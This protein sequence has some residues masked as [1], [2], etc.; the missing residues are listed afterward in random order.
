MFNRELGDVVDRAL[1]GDLLE[2]QRYRVAGQVLDGTVDLGDHRLAGLDHRD[3]D[4]ALVLA[5]HQ[6]SRLGGLGRQK[7][8]NK[9]AVV[10]GG[11]AE[12]FFALALDGIGGNRRQAQAG[13][14]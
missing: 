7:G 12:H 8:G 11:I 5:A 14:Q 13:N 10:H 4:H 3:V 9:G 2:L 1:F 6:F